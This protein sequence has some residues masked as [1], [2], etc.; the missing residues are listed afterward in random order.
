MLRDGITAKQC[1]NLPGDCCF[2]NPLVMTSWKWGLALLAEIL[3]QAAHKTVNNTVTS[4]WK[5]LPGFK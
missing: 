4:A 1:Y 5:S 2:G 3:C